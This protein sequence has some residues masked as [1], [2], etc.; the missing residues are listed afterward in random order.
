MVSGVR[1]P[2]DA[3]E[4]ETKNFN[5]RWHAF[6]AERDDLPAYQQRDVQ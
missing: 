4:R 5:L 3:V 1:C 6:K 2:D